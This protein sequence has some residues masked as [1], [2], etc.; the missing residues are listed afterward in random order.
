MLLLEFLQIDCPLGILSC[1]EFGIQYS[2]CHHVDPIIAS[3]TVPCP[4]HFPGEMVGD[5]ADR[6]AV[7][8]TPCLRLT[9]VGS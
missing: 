7:Q 4:V 2:S 3:N 9:A 5:Q 1:E 8:A 6:K